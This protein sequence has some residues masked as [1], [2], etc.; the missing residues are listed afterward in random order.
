MLS[1]A[2]GGA[3]EGRCGDRVC[4]GARCPYAKVLLNRS[5]DTRWKR[6][7]ALPSISRTRN[8]SSDF[9]VVSNFDDG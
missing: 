1:A 3:G 8:L 4:R 9:F 5:N 2:R 6:T 7:S